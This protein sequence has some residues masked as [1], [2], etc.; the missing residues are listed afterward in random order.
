[1]VLTR[2]QSYKANK[3]QNIKL[4]QEDYDCVNTLM[5]LRSADNQ[6]PST[7]VFPENV[8]INVETHSYDLRQRVTSSNYNIHDDWDTLNDPTWV[9][10]NQRRSS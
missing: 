6:L 8:K 1:M 9:P 5:T 10:W 3:M 7:H 2:S 4:T